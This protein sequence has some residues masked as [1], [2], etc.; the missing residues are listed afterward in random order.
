MFDAETIAGIDRI[1][2][3]LK[4]EPA[5]LQAVAEVESAGKVFALVKGRQ[6]PVIRWEGHYYDRRLK[7][8]ARD[9]ARA[10]KLASPTAG[11]IK[12]PAS[13]AKRWDMVTRASQIDRHAALESFSIGL[14]QVMTA[15]W[16]ALG[17]AKVDDLIKEARRDAK[18]QI[19]LMVKYCAAFG[20]ID[21]LQRLDFTGFAR[22]YNGPGFR[23]GGYHKK[24]A[25]AYKRLSGK[26]AVSAATGMLRMGSSGAR[27]R[28]LQALLLRAGYA[29]KVDG[30][31]GP[32]TRDAVKGFQRSQ[33]I[34]ADGVAGP[35]TFRRLENWKV[36]PEEKV[37]QQKPTDVKEVKDAAGGG[38]VLTLVVSLR[39]QIAETATSLTGIEAE[40][41]QTV[42]NVL[43]AGSGAIGVGLAVW[44]FWGWVRSKRTDEGDV[45]PVGI[46]PAGDSDPVLA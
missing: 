42:A 38:V 2:A 29:V 46:A 23:K 25:A 18:G 17:F 37:G 16:K 43:M 11:A 5:A 15:H 10:E 3:A 21:E 28:E 40:T 19:E 4:V 7:G 20:L 31:Y 35:E 44:A 24:M 34:K 39:N 27:V 45:E 13:Q 14:G 41:A 36:T 1:A 9:R 32:S 12:N 22:G 33:K 30:D 26:P 6:E 8:A